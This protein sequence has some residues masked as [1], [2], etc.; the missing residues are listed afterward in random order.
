MSAD[1]PVNRPLC[2]LKALSTKIVT[3]I[4]DLP[5]TSPHGSDFGHDAENI[6]L[7]CDG[8]VTP[9]TATAQLHGHCEVGRQRNRAD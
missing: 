6:G 9:G 3:D 4:N 2:G 1:W 5:T 7:A 8:K